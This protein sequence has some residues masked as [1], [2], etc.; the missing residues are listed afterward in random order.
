MPS[1]PS[2]RASRPRRRQAACCAGFHSK[3]VN[4]VFTLQPPAHSAARLGC[5]TRTTDDR[6]ASWAAPTS[7]REDTSLQG[8]IFKGRHTRGVRDQ[9]TLDLFLNWRAM[10]HEVT[11]NSTPNRLPVALGAAFTKL[12]RIIPDRQSGYSDILVTVKRYLLAAAMSIL[13]TVVSGTALSLS[14]RP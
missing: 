13:S 2:K 4:Q 6:R 1:L 12:M 14:P 10:M 11:V 8:N 7:P 5:S 3:A 9:A